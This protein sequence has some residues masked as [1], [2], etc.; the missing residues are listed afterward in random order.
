VASHALMW[1]LWKA[2]QESCF[3]TVQSIASPTLEAADQLFG[4]S[5]VASRHAAL[6]GLDPPELTAHSLARWRLIGTVKALE[7]SAP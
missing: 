1:T 2:G 6:K 7:R 3:G 4:A 5:T